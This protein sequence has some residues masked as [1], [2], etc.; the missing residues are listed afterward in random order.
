[1][2]GKKRIAFALLTALLASTGCCRLYD[3]WC[4]PTQTSYAVPA[5]QA[6]PCVPCCPAG[7]VAGAAPV[8]AA[9]AWNQPAVVAPRACVPCQ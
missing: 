7:T 2:I 8:A 5:A 9:P 6:V 3:R 1:M 4:G